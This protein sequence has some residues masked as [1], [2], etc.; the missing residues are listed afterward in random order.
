MEGY[1]AWRKLYSLVPAA[2][3]SEKLDDIAMRHPSF[4]SSNQEKDDD[5]V[6]LMPKT[7]FF[8][9]INASF[10]SSDESSSTDSKE[11]L[12]SMVDDM[13]EGLLEEIYD[14]FYL[15]KNPYFDDKK[16]NLNHAI[17]SN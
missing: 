7:K 5:L 13:V 8:A 1:A 4:S 9:R 12:D 6:N 16:A 17:L 14:E 3:K 10:Y 15:I 11:C 2:A